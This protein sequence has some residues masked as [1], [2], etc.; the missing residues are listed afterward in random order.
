[1]AIDKALARALEAP[2]APIFVVTGPAGLLV[3]R[4]AAAIVDRVMPMVGPPSFNVLTL[5]AS[6]ANAEDAIGMARTPPMMADK[7]LVVLRGLESAKDPFFEALEGYLES[8]NPDTVLV[9]SGAGY[10]PVVKGG[11]A[12]GARLQKKMAAVATV[13]TYSADTLRPI[14]FV[15]ETAA[16]LGN[17]LSR[18]DAALLVAV[19]G[20]DLGTLLCEVEKA[21]LYVEPG[22]PI[23]AAAITEAC[24]SVAEQEVWALTGALARRDRRVALGALH[25]LLADGDSAHKLLGLIVWQ[26]RVMLRLREILIRGGSYQDAL[27][28]ARGRA[29]LVRAVQTAMDK[30]TLAAAPILTRLARAH[31][32]MNGMKAGE[33]RVL[34]ALVVEMT[35]A[36]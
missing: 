5:H 13:L 12:W 18:T 24:S 31:R 29:E 25:R 9:L 20:A 33:D 30:G 36:P 34:E 17:P 22:A 23:D 35:S 4:A 28:E 26:I 8:P 3:Q 16:G 11:K 21:S 6:D 7:R 15:M 1:M 10:P 19:V 27:A 2:P 32:A 14:D